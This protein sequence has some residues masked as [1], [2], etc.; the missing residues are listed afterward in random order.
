LVEARHSSVSLHLFTPDRLI[1]S[2]YYRPSSLP[3]CFP[4]FINRC[5][6]QSWLLLLTQK[7]LIMTS[8]PRSLNPPCDPASRTA[9][10]HSVQL[11]RTR[12]RKISMGPALYPFTRLRP[13]KVFQASMITPGAEIQPGVTWVCAVWYPVEFDWLTP[14]HAFRTS[15]CQ[16]ILCPTC[17]CCLVRHGCARRHS[18][19]A[20]A[21]RRSNSR[22][23]PL[24]RHKPSPHIP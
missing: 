17:I 15:Y 14:C 11:S 9:F 5:F 7:P 6:S 10:P 18:S 21:W 1:S 2:I 4:C 8:Q 19:Y 23:R 16:N 12:L 20:Q 24:R 22:R 3:S 13:S